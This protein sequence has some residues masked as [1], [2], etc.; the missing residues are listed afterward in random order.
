MLYKL[1][2]HVG[3]R[4]IPPG[5]RV[6][7]NMRTFPYT[8]VSAA[9]RDLY[10]QTSC[11]ARVSHNVFHSHPNGPKLYGKRSIKIAG[12]IRAAIVN[13][14]PITI[15][16]S[17][18]TVEYPLS[19]VYLYEH[20]VRNGGI[21]WRTRARKIQFPNYGARQQSTNNTIT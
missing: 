16:S 4:C 17:N 10:E 14:P 2:K 19:V 11:R 9:V 15:H 18:T 21:S 20:S 3:A 5:K 8:P 1:T 7:D 12:K 13:R 6:P